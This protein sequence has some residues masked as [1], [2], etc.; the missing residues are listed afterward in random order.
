MMMA[1]ANAGGVVNPLPIHRS[2]PLPA[3]AYAAIGISVLLHAAGAVWLYN[4]NFTMPEAPARDDPPASTIT[5]WNPPEPDPV[6]T[7][8]PP[9]PPIAQHS[10]TTVV[11]SP[12]DPSPIPVPDTPGETAPIGDPITL[13][14]LPDPVVGGTATEPTRPVAPRLLRKTDW[15]RQPTAPPHERALPQRGNNAGVSGRVTLSCSVTASGSVTGCSV[16]SESP[17]GYGF[18]RAALGLAPSFEMRPR[19]V[20][21]APVEGARVSIPLVFS[22]GD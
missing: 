15:V 22:L 5:I 21:G 7:E 16:A 13:T 1:V 3:W 20:D 10:P 17:S 18:G 8:A 19:T 14:P 12:V 9:R 11:D 4:Q 2:K 6:T